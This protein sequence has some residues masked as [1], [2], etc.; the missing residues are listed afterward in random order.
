MTATGYDHTKVVSYQSY[1]RIGTVY[2]L[3]VVQTFT[4]TGAQSSFSLLRALLTLILAAGIV[5]WCVR[6][7]VTVASLGGIIIGLIAIVIVNLII[8]P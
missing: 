2:V 1:V 5:M 3:G 4:D 6:N 7:G 8:G